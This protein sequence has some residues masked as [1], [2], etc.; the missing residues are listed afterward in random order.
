MHRLS[1]MLYLLQLRGMFRSGIKM[2][3]TAFERCTKSNYTAID[4]TP[5]ITFIWLNYIA[6]TDAKAA[7]SV[8]TVHRRLQKQEK[9]IISWASMGRD[10][11]MK[12]NLD[13]SLPREQ[14]KPRELSG[15]ILNP[16]R[17]FV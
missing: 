5:S 6:R 11:F 14:H 8:P 10:F 4:S 9:E 15:L 12:L 2:A 1:S 16:Q 3:L 7:K 17:L 13:T